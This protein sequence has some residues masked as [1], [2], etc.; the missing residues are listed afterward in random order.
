MHSQPAPTAAP[1]CSTGSTA[2]LFAM[3]CESNFG[4]QRY[5][6]HIVGSV[7]QHSPW[8]WQAPFVDPQ[9]TGTSSD[10]QLHMQQRQPASSTASMNKEQQQWYVLLDAAKACASAPPDLRSCPADFVVSTPAPLPPL[11]LPPSRLPLGTGT[12]IC[13]RMPACWMVSLYQ[14]YRP[15]LQTHIS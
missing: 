15:L 8:R 3:P 4:G 1:A 7:Q 9:A 12:F 5:D 13:R 10:R 6:P 11:P 2:C 14:R